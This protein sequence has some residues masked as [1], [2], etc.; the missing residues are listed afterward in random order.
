MAAA[1]RR[2]T[3]AAKRTRPA[4][5]PPQ[6]SVRWFDAV[7]RNCSRRYPFAACSSTPSKPAAMARCEAE[8]YSPMAFSMSASVIGVGT[9][10][11]CSPWLSVHIFPGLAT[12]EAPSTRAPAGRFAG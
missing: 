3:S 6:P 10:C 4:T 9:G 7:L 8:T 12:A 1:T 2:A 11:G 5:G